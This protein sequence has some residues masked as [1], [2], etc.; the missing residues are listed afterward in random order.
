MTS[1]IFSSTVIMML[2]RMGSL[3]ALEQDKGNSFWRRWL[4]LANPYAGVK[5][6]PG[7]CLFEYQAFPQIQTQ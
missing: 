4:G 1:T 6:I 7:F 5:F 2:T 3:N